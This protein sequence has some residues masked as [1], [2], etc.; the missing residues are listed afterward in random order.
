MNCSKHRFGSLISRNIYLQPNF[1]ISGSGFQT[2]VHGG[3]PGGP[4]EDSQKLSLFARF[5]TIYDLYVFKF[6]HISQSLSQ[7]IAWK[8]CPCHLYVTDDVYTFVKSGV[9]KN[10]GILYL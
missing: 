9:H 6:A 8:R 1:V 4:R 10:L 3:F 2:G 5:L 7:C